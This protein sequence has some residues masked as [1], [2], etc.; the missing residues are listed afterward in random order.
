MKAT[1]NIAITKNIDGNGTNG[2]AVNYTFAEEDKQA[3]IDELLWCCQ[4]SPDGW[5]DFCQTEGGYPEVQILQCYVSGLP[6]EEVIKY[7]I[8]KDELNQY[9]SPEDFYNSI[10]TQEEFGI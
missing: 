10:L 3:N 5:A 7:L 8:E 2:V 6:K 1:Q 4:T 9:D